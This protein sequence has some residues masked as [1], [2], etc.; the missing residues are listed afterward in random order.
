LAALEIMNK[1]FFTLLFFSLVAYGQQERVAIINTV[2]DRDS[3]GVS[4][5]IYLTDRLRETA[6]NVLPK[7]RYGVMTTE[8][9]VAF[10][11]SQERAEKECRESSCLAELGRKVSADYVAQ[12]RIG[13]F[14][15]DLTIKVELYSSKSGVMIGSFTGDSKY[16]QGLRTI[17]D[18]NAPV[19]FKKLP[20]VS[21]G[22]VVPFIAG[23]IGGVQT[24]GGDYEFEGAKRYLVNVTSNP[25]GASLSFNGIPDVHCTKTPCNAELLEGDVR[26]IANLEQYEMADTT[27]SV[28]QNKQN[29]N[30]RLKANFGVLEI[31]P[32]YSDN[33]G[34]DNGWFFTIN[35]KAQSSYEN[36][37]SPGNYEV[38]L[39]HECY[40]DISFKAGINKGKH[41][42]FNIANSMKLKKG[43]LNLSAE[44]D[45][46]PV[47][48]PVYVNSKQVGETP[49]SGSVPICAKIE[50]G[51]GRETINVNIEH[52]VA[53]TYTYQMDTEE[54]RRRQEE[55]RQ[56]ELE[57]ERLEERRRIDAENEE[58]MRTAWVTGVIFFLGGG[59][60]LNMNEIDPDYFKSVGGQWNSFSFEFY[61]RNLKF[62]RFGFNFDLGFL[63]VER[64]WIRKTQPNVLT[65]SI[66]SAYV[67]IHAF[68]RLYPVDFLFLSGGVGWNKFLV[69]AKEIK[70]GSTEQEDI[71][72]V[73]FSTLVFP[74]GGGICLCNSASNDFGGRFA[75]GGG[76]IIEGLYN[77]VPFKER[78]AK[79]I[80]INAGFIVR[81][82]WKH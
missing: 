35:D 19:L 70:S 21:G 74:V 7:P 45:G 56:A 9:I 34:H 24:A 46:K 33:I 82:R 78:T 63:G 3:I 8:S 60:S 47:G 13:R 15:G 11:G 26:I 76:L 72:V 59:V 67:K 54:S 50:I 16:L 43:G 31:K 81:W 75:F 4:E 64:D 30:I 51:A 40:E 36:R 12:A 5:L 17:I 28:K 29:I 27:V 14:E 20:D 55:R 79:Y 77:I 44:A 6:A 1:L 68:T 69:G 32:A 2:D 38:K 48:E 23:G 52:N 65:D 71:Y 25:E 37:L 57:T 58:A 66:V 10:L 22:R 80:T 39:S 41:E 61:K 18:E 42:V 49:F 62:F 53:K 73:D